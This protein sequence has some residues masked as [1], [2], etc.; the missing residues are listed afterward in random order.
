M[1]PESLAF[2]ASPAMFNF[3]HELLPSSISNINAAPHLSIE[4][5][6]LPE[7]MKNP[8]VVSLYKRM[9]SSVEVQEGLWQEVVRLKSQVR[10]LETTPYEHIL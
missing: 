1:N 10:A 2:A 6:G 9:T 3:D 5:L 4:S 7:L 8:H